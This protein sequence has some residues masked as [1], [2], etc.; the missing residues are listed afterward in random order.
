V[1]V[2]EEPEIKQMSVSKHAGEQVSKTQPMG[3]LQVRIVSAKIEKNKLD[4]FKKIYETEIIPALLSTTGCRYA[5][6]SENLKEANE[7]LSI[8]IW[9]SKEDIERYEHSG[10]FR[11]LLE[12]VNHT[13]TDF[14]QWMT[15]L[16]KTSAMSVSSSADTDVSRYKLVTAKSFRE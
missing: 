10:Q 2:E 1:P 5:F 13:F 12:K 6:L 3:D 9:D 7:F 8:S 15:A 4:E 11:A 16:E 14:I